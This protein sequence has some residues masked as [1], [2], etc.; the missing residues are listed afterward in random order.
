MYI[1]EAFIKEKQR[2]F[3]NS[4]SKR[5]GFAQTT[6]H[7]IIQLAVETRSPCGTYIR[8]LDLDQNYVD[9]WNE[10]VKTSI[11]NATTTRRVTDVLIMK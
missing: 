3:L 2:L 1:H 4:L 6:L 8:S 7:Q 9:S 5:D 11:K 10:S